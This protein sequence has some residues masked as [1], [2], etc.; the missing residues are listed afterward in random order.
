MCSGNSPELDGEETA[1]K[2]SLALIPERRAARI[3]FGQRSSKA[4]GGIKVVSIGPRSNVNWGKELIV[5]L[6]RSDSELGCEAIGHESPPVLL[7]D[8]K[9]KLL[10]T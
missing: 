1:N 2:R 4:A 6:H 10:F 7:L 3:I 9:T 5:S 8:W